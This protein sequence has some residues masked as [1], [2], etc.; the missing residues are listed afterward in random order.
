MRGA[1]SHALPTVLLQRASGRRRRWE[2]GVAFNDSGR[3]GSF[4][5]DCKVDAFLHHLGYQL[6]LW[7]LT[8]GYPTCPSCLPLCP[9]WE[10]GAILLGGSTLLSPLRTVRIFLHITVVDDVLPPSAFFAHGA[11]SARHR[12]TGWSCTTGEGVVA[13][14][15]TI[16][17]TTRRK[18]QHVFPSQRRAGTAI[19]QSGSPAVVESMVGRWCCKARTAE[20][21]QG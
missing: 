7:M 8:F 1:E 20:L 2:E 11:C 19:R 17:T 5:N 21:L 4:D 15:Q 16:A 14:Q 6:Q 9:A 18:Q 13:D 12:G 3:P 10:K